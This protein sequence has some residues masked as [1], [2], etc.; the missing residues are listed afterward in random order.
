MGEATEHS[1][2]V[3]NLIP[4]QTAYNYNFGYVLDSDRT[5]EHVYRIVNTTDR[6]IRIAKIIN[7]KTCCGTIHPISVPEIQPGQTVEFKVEIKIG[8]TLGLLQHSATVETDSITSP[9]LQFLTAATVIPKVRIDASTKAIGQVRAGETSEIEFQI[10]ANGTKLENP[11]QITN[12][13][14]NSTLPIEWLGEASET[15]N[16]NDIVTRIRRFQLMLPAEEAGVHTSK[17]TVRDENKIL[18]VYP[19][20]REVLPVIRSTPTGVVF[21]KDKSSQTVVLRSETNDAF[22]ILSATSQENQIDASFTNMSNSLE[23]SITIRLKN[24]GVPSA[25]RGNIAIGTDH[26]KQRKLILHYFI[27][28]S[29]S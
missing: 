29:K 25:K 26:P 7:N 21:S 11:I 18:L 6:L 24:D 8:K 5:R 16:S 19:F 1:R 22:S 9:Q 28:S 17:L 4:L 13:N 10:E 20:S 14:V 12:E 23:Q 27:I 3:T 15:T 2:S